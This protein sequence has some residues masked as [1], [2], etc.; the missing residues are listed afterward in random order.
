M[1]IAIHGLGKSGTT[2][3]HNQLKH[4][5]PKYK[6]YFE[7]NLFLNKN[8]KDVISKILTYQHFNYAYASQF[9]KRILMVRDPRDRVVSATLYAAWNFIPFWNPKN[10]DKFLELV[11]QK[12][13][14]PNSVSMADLRECISGTKFVAP[15][16]DHEDTLIKTLKRWRELDYFTIKY[17]DYVDGKTEALEEYLGFKLSE[18]RDIPDEHKRVARSKTYGEW[19]NWFTYSDITSFKPQMNKFMEKFGYNN[20]WLSDWEE[21][22]NDKPVI[23]PEYSSKYVE[24]LQKERTNESYCIYSNPRS[25]LFAEGKKVSR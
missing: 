8:Q 23:N 10:G 22:L 19:K 12:E 18:N 3:L 14:D 5:L 25:C 4:T 7:V 1:R 17:E 24:K 2:A 9:D 20:D 6:F 16:L 21:E 13:K 15:L 11:K